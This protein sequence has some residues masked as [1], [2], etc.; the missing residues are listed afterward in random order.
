MSV[1]YN[2]KHPVKA[3]LKESRLE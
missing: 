2:A 1:H 3:F